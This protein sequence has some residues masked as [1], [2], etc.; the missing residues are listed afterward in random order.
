[1]ATIV[2]FGMAVNFS[3]TPKGVYGDGDFVKWEK[4]EIEVTHEIMKFSALAI[5]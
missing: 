1:M 5:N 4:N 2:C 3:I